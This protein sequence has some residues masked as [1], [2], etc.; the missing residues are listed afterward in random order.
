M[1]LATASSAKTIALETVSPSLAIGRGSSRFSDSGRLASADVPD[2]DSTLAD[3]KL[4]TTQDILHSDATKAVPEAAGTV[5]RFDKCAIEHGHGEADKEKRSVLANRSNEVAGA[6]SSHLPGDNDESDE[7]GESKGEGARQDDRGRSRIRRRDG[8]SSSEP[9]SIPVATGKGTGTC[10]G[11]GEAKSRA[12]GLMATPSRLR[13]YREASTNGCD[14]DPRWNRSSKGMM[15]LDEVEAAASAGVGWRGL[16]R[17]T[18]AALVRQ[19]S[20]YL[21]PGGVQR[22]QAIIFWYHKVS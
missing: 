13:G 10:T 6:G 5:L 2:A 19:L 3:S 17:E 16:R 8:R 22:R 18:V 20:R 4:T 14:V 11:T 1:W 21:W 15:G 12:S 9:Q 7:G